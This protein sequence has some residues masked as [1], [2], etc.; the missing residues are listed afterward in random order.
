MKSNPKFNLLLSFFLIGIFY[1]CQS[2]DPELSGNTPQIIENKS[3]RLVFNSHL[4]FSNTINS[5][6]RNV[7]VSNSTELLKNFYDVPNGFKSINEILDKEE[8]L[9]IPKLISIRNRSLDEPFVLSSDS[10]SNLIPDK[11]FGAVLNKDLEIEVA[12]IIYK[13]TPY[14]TF[15]TPANNID[16]LYLHLN[17]FS[18]EQLDNLRALKNSTDDVYEL[19]NNVFFVDTFKGNETASNERI[20][21]DPNNTIYQVDDFCGPCAPQIP[22]AL[23][24]AEY[25][26]FTVYNF[27]AQ[28]AVGKLIE[29]AFGTNTSFE[30]EFVWNYR[31]KVK[32]YAFNYAV[33]QSVGL[34]ATMQKRGWTGFWAKHNDARAQKLVLGWDA[35]LLTI[36]I[37][38]ALPIGYASF[39][40][41]GI[42]KELLQFA[43]FDLPTANVTDASIPFQNKPLIDYDQL[44][45]ILN[46]TVSSSLSKISELIWKET[47]Q[48][49]ANASFEIKQEQIKSYRK[50]FPDKIKLFI[51]R[52]EAVQLNSNEMS[53][54]LDRFF[55]VSY[56]ASGTAQYSDF[57]K[58]VL[59]PTFNQKKLYELEGASVFGAAIFN[60]QTKGIRIIKEIE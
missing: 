24:K 3:N 60:G 42:T 10:V 35:L 32:L 28:T 48:L 52:N 27:G 58:N 43:N 56:S 34:N 40:S 59:G 57:S 44:E 38:Y 8:S 23:P 29:G 15:Y 2:I 33:Y 30:Q 37:P 6:G 21:F 54:V 55:Q 39:P 19:R 1:G 50:I 17:D 16:S 7:N 51:G 26:N 49:L 11:A 41:K 25:N 46:K 53:F 14:G 12:G 31:I 18:L 4:S 47:E 5:L 20:S 45:K 13:V 36:K 9:E 22:T